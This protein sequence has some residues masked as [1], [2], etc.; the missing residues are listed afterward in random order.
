MPLSV[1]VCV[2][3]LH[4][5]L[6]ILIIPLGMSLHLEEQMASFY[7]QKKINTCK[8]VPDV[9]DAIFL[10]SEYIGTTHAH[11]HAFKY[12]RIQYILKCR[13]CVVLHHHIILL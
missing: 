8:E 6:R 13:L 9:H 5:H 7:I 3:V 11:A 1:F 12:S 10:F 4:A 2:S